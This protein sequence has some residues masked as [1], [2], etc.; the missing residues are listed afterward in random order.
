MCSRLETIAAVNWEPWYLRVT[1]WSCEDDCKYHCMHLQ[2]E[3]RGIQGLPPAKY[4]G[5][6]PFVRAFGHQEF[7]SSLFSLFNLAAHLYGYMKL[8]KICMGMPEHASK[9]FSTHRPVCSVGPAS[10]V[11]PRSQRPKRS[12]TSIQQSTVA[13][14]DT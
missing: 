8:R 13:T 6:W 4:Y 2:E 7:C 14:V 3:H 9:Y 11:M 5:K 1:G 10:F 12:S